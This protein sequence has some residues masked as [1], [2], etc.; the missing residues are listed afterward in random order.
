MNQLRTISMATR[1]VMTRHPGGRRRTDLSRVAFGPDTK[2][3]A[4]PCRS[5]LRGLPPS[6][7]R[8]SLCRCLRGPQQQRV[9][10]DDR[11]PALPQAAMPV[12]RRVAPVAD[13]GLGLNRF[14]AGRA[15][16]A[17]HCQSPHRTPW[18]RPHSRIP[19]LRISCR[20][21]QAKLTPLA[22][23]C[24]ASE[25]GTPRFVTLATLAHSYRIPE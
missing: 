25:S 3:P 20:S 15:L 18:P 10:S 8:H 9:Q 1:C 14:P 12:G 4:R 21:L 7:C 2:A 23:G 6:R 13:G 16:A 5:G 17:V 11:I 19:F 24:P 22:T